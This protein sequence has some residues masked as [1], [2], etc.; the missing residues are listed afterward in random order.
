M[1]NQSEPF[2]IRVCINVSPNIVKPS[3]A[4]T[5]TI[6]RPLLHYYKVYAFNYKV[7]LTEGCNL[8]F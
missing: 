8:G 2:I 4:V 6:T 1:H 7:I 3:L 5:I